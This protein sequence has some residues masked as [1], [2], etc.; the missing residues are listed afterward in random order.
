MSQCQ[1]CG[2]ALT[3]PLV[4]TSCDAL[5]PA[6]GEAQHTP[7]E[8]LG[9]EP[10]WTVDTRQ[11]RRTLLDLSRRVHPDYF[12]TAGEEQRELAERASA[13][14]NEAHEILGDDARRA[15]W[16]VR[17]LGGPSDSEERQMP[18]VFLMQ[19]LEWNEVLDSARGASEGSSEWSAMLQLGEEL[20]SERGERLEAIGDL[21]TPL[22]EHGAPA[23]AELRREL[24]AV[25]YIDRTQGE[26][27]SLRLEASLGGS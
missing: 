22:P 11:L 2:A 20:S 7:F 13:A 9:L 21:L 10:S 3:T 8:A 5:Q 18:Q 14:L 4:C 23:L 26:L 15:D 27:R 25:R 19:V 12:A 1:S 16:L 6:S 17:S 24:N